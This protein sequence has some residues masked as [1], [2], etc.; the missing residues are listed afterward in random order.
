MGLSGPALTL[1]ATTLPQAVARTAL[2]AAG[3]EIGSGTHVIFCAVAGVS[4]GTIAAFCVFAKPES[5]SKAALRVLPDV[6]GGKWGSVQL[7]RWA[8]MEA[9]NGHVSQIAV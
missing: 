3:F 2:L 4:G 1:S 9:G 7:N 8:L 5:R 6:I